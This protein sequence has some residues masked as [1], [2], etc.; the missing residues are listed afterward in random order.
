MTAS[1]R[2]EAWREDAMLNPDS[3]PPPASL[4]GLD[5]RIARGLANDATCT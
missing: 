5:G 1:S 4:C 2:R 3:C